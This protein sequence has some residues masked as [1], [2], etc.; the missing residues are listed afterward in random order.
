MRGN[1]NRFTPSLCLCRGS[2]LAAALGLGI[3]LGV[4]L[5]H[6]LPQAALRRLLALTM[7]AAGAAIVVRLTLSAA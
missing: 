5:A 1:T 3:A 2:V 4:P 6:A 7:I